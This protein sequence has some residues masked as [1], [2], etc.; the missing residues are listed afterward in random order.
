M[1]SL[2][3]GLLRPEAVLEEDPLERV[4]V[5]ALELDRKTLHGASGAEAALQVAGELAE[6]E[7]A[8]GEPLQDDDLPAAAPLLAA[9]LDRLGAQ[10]L[11]RRSRGRGRLR[12]RIGGT[13]RQ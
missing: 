1:R 2:P 3:A 13:G 9:H 6:I 5:I 11:R 4:A 8:L 12:R 7:A 10:F